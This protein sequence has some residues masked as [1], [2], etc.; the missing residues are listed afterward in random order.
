VN[1]NG[2]IQAKS[3]TC[4]DNWQSVNADGNPVKLFA[5]SGTD[6]AQK[7]IVSGNII[8]N[9]A[10][11][12]CLDD[13]GST[14]ADGTSLDLYTCNGT[15]AQV[16]K[17]TGGYS[18]TGDPKQKWAL[19]YNDATK[20]GYFEI[21]SPISD[22]N[23]NLHYCLDVAASGKTDGTI[24]QYWGCDQTAAQH[25]SYGANGSLVNVNSGKCLDTAGGSTANGTQTVINTCN[26]SA[27]QNW[28]TP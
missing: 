23:S 11:G 7:W 9:P 27:S 4:L 18:I 8:K 14:T 25:W 10:T 3:G 15:N 12:K 26:G 5:C 22:I 6:A 16:W 20:S 1:S 28:T 19:K 24:V 17:P 2:T 21:T 13:P